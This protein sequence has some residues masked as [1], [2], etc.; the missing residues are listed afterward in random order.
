MSDTYLDVLTRIAEQAAVRA[1][2]RAMLEPPEAMQQRSP[3]RLGG[4]STLMTCEKMPRRGVIAPLKISA[5]GSK[6]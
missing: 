6:P 5:Y 4:H 1:V 2:L 3:K